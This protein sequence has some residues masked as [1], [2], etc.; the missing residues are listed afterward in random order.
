MDS[1]HIDID[2]FWLKD[3]DIK[4]QETATIAKYR[5]TDYRIGGPLGLDSNSGFES[6]IVMLKPIY[7]RK[8][9]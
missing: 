5:Y 9:S 7:R 2:G 8:S 3:A 4:V 6:A 1:C